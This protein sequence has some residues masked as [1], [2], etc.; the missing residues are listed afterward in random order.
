MRDWLASGRPEIG[1]RPGDDDIVATTHDGNPIPRY[2][3][4][5]PCPGIVGDQET[6]AFYAGQGVGL[7]T[8]VLP[9]G[10]LVAR[11]IE[12]TGIALE[13]PNYQGRSS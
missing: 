13:S 3:V 11:L 6:L 8:D 1:Q 7:I 10:E 12:E 2:H 5:Q 4:T 9:A